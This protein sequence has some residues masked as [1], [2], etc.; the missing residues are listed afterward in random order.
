MYLGKGAE[1]S[2]TRNLKKLSLLCAAVVLINFL[3]SWYYEELFFHFF[4]LYSIL[5]MVFFFLFI[6]SSPNPQ[7]LSNPIIPFFLEIEKV[8]LRF[9]PF[10]D[11]LSDNKQHQRTKQNSRR[12]EDADPHIYYNCDNNGI[13]AQ[14]FP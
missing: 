14:L 4:V 5:D 1:W 2:M 7:L 13:Y 8:F 6:A 12:S 3:S 11:H 10:P 9:Q